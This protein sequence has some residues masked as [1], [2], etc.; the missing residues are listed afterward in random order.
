MALY[1]RT[2]VIDLSLCHFSIIV[3]LGE[4]HVLVQASVGRP[5][6]GA[7]WKPTVGR[8]DDLQ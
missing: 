2:S 7:L 5:C 8:L 4:S 6:D 1:R 3:L